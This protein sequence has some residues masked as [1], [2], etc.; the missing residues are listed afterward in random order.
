MAGAG[1]K[2]GAR[3][4]PETSLDASS[5][6]DAAPVPT[7]T[8][9]AAGAGEAKVVRKAEARAQAGAAAGVTV[10]AGIGART[11]PSRR[12]AKPAESVRKVTRGGGN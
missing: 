7:V 9:K 1:V 6:G 11:G 2:A 8:V 10:E 12:E 3:V 5:K 4:Q